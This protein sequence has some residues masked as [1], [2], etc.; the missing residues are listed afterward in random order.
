MA[1][2]V[3]CQAEDCIHLTMSPRW[4]HR[5]LGKPDMT[6]CGRETIEIDDEGRCGDYE[7]GVTE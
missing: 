4:A 2:K 7:K 6:E 3:N 1:T 5:P